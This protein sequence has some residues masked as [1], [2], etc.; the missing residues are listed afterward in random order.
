MG[1]SLNDKIKSVVDD[2]NDIAIEYC[3]EFGENDNYNKYI[4]KWLNL[5]GSGKILDVG[6]GC[7]KNCN[8]INSFDGFISTGIDFSDNMLE[9]ARKRN[10][11]VEVFKMDM[12]ELSFD[13]NSFDG[14]LSNCSMIH[15]PIELVPQ[16]LLGFKR[17]LKENGRLLLI[18]LE[19][20]GEEMVEEPYRA[21]QNVFVYTKFYSL[22]EIIGILHN[23]GFSINDIEI[24]KTESENELGSGELIVYAQNKEISLEEKK[25]EVKRLIRVK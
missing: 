21:G 8:Y 4:D 20:N 6:C 19:G 16:T 15:T 18:L 12:T 9:E 5:V 23:S 1:I 10:P 2:Y 14:I 17:V 13:D 24:R 3:D 7:G 11:S 25:N 22:E